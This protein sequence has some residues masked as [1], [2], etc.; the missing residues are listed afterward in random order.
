MSRSTRSAKFAKITTQ[1]IQQYVKT[2]QSSPRE[3]NIPRAREENKILD[4][5]KVTELTPQQ[6]QNVDPKRLQKLQNKEF[7]TSAVPQG[8]FY[9]TA[10]ILNDPEYLDVTEAVHANF[11]NI[12][13]LGK[14]VNGVA[15]ASSLDNATDLIVVKSSLNPQFDD[16]QHELFV[17]LFCTNK[18]RGVV[19]NFSYIFGGFKCGAPDIEYSGKEISSVDIC[20]DA[21]NSVHYVIYEKVPGQS[22][23]KMAPQFNVPGF[24]STYLQV[25]FALNLANKSCGFTHYDLHPGNVMMRRPFNLNLAIPYDEGYIL[26]TD[27]AT[28]IDYGYSHIKYKGKSYGLKG[29]EQ[30]GVLSNKSFPLFDAYKLLCGLMLI[31]KNTPGLDAQFD[32]GAKIL[33]FFTDEDPRSVIEQQY[34]Y[35]YM[36]P[37]ING[38]D[39]ISLDPLIAHIRANCDTSM[40]VNQVP[41][42]HKLLQCQDHCLTVVDVLS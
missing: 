42:D 12:K 4:N 23:D 39:K 36:L 38:L 27:I 19:P 8:I 30:W 18:L 34:N 28:I 3:A 7:Y 2:H 21:Q 35:Y 22:L 32:E 11:T 13:I 10:S 29:I 17:G 37:D 6:L 31:F 25:I 41:S 9:F 26:T 24:V 15:L 14:G 1:E 33:R 40:L 16:L 5:V 20:S